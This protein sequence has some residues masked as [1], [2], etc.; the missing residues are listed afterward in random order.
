MLEL[1]GVKGLNPRDVFAAHI[2]IGDSAILLEGTVLT[3]RGNRARVRL[4]I[5]STSVRALLER[6][7]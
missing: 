7:A 4:A 1:D 6:S 2:S 5:P 3:V